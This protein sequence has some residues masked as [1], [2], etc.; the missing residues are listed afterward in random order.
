MSNKKRISRRENFNDASKNKK[1]QRVEDS[2]CQKELIAESIKALKRDRQKR[3]KENKRSGYGKFLFKFSFINPT[4]WDKRTSINTDYRCRSFNEEKQYLDFFKEFIYPY[5]IPKVL[6]KAAF[7]KETIIIGNGGSK[8][9]PDLEIITFAKKWINDIVSGDSF[10]KR[11]KACFTKGEAHFFLNSEIGYKDPSSLIELMFYSKS[12]ARKIGVKR[13]RVIAKIFTQKF[14]K[15]W[16]HPIVAGFLDLIA[17]N[18]DYN[19]ENSGLHDICDFVLSEV[20]KD[21]KARGR[22]L[23]FSFSGRTMAS[24]ISLANEWHAQIIREQQAIN[25]LAAPRRPYWQA[26]YPKHSEITSWKGIGIS[27][28]GIEDDVSVWSFKELC[29]VQAL[30]NEGRLMKNCVSS[31]SGKCADGVSSIFHVSR[32]YIEEKLSVDIAT[33]E[34]SKSRTLVQARGKCNG[35]ISLTYM[36]T[37]KKWA[38]LNRIKVSI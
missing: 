35:I 10:Y 1:R 20:E 4:P 29:D 31:Y 24:V 14:T 28:S 22:R 6:L 25:A 12:M 33:L 17:R 11:N 30:L 15:H 34:I 16:K 26:L 9:S 5:R 2:V 21:H 7:E 23:P 18:I 19:I 3:K 32:F 38:Q 36:K 13:S 8:S 27:H 37:I